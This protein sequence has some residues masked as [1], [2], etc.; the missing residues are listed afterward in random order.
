MSKL[1]WARGRLLLA[2][3]QKAGITDPRLKD[4]PD[5]IGRIEGNLS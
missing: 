2:P 1:Q 4:A 5:Y 3:I